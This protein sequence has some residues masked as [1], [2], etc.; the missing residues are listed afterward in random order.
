MHVG[1]ALL[2]ALTV[3]TPFSV[4]LHEGGDTLATVTAADG[5]Q[6]E[7]AA[8]TGDYAFIS[9]DCNG[10]V[11]RRHPASFHEG[12]LRVEQPIGRR[13]F[14]VGVRAGIVVDDLAGGDGIVPPSVP[15]PGELQPPRVVT[16]N[17]YLNPYLAFNPP[18]G[19]VGAGVVFH[20][21]E[22]PTAGEGARDVQHHPL[23]DLSVHVRFGGEQHYF[24]ARWMEGMPLYSDGGLLTLGVGG[25]PASGPWTFFGGLGAGGPYEGAGFAARFGRDVGDWN[26]SVR[27]RLGV[28]GDAK[29]AG[30]AL[31]VSYRGKH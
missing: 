30:V 14:A 5:T 13:G 12:A 15:P 31:G 25:R 20:E 3:V 22:F 18:N 10:Q 7:I 9:R 26:L 24:E 27:S 16:T 4:Q 17:R 8:G 21:R 2:I 28:S 19:S 6:Y 23:N 29:A 11:L 1:R